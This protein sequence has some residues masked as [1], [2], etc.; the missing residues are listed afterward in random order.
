MRR[1]LAIAFGLSLALFTAPATSAH[2]SDGPEEVRA[3]SQTGVCS[4]TCD[5]QGCGLPCGV[6]FF[7]GTFTGAGWCSMPSA[8]GCEC[9]LF[10]CDPCG[11]GF[12][13]SGEE[14]DL[15]GTCGP[16][17]DAG[18]P[19]TSFGQCST[20][21]CQPRGGNG[22]AANCS[23][24][25]LVAT[26]FRPVSYVVSI[27]NVALTLSLSGS[28]TFA[29]GKPK[30]PPPPPCRPVAIRVFASSPLE[31]QNLGCVCVQG[32]ANPVVYG[33]GNVG[34]GVIGCADA[35]GILRA[36]LTLQTWVLPSGCNPGT[37]EDG[38]DGVPC[39][40]DDPMRQTAWAVQTQ[41]AC[42][43]DCNLDGMVTVDE[44]LEGVNIA[45]SNLDL[46]GC[47]SFDRNGDMMVSV[48]EILAAVSNTLDGCQGLLVEETGLR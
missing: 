12:I 42:S 18:L 44:L 32:T 6:R 10:E 30:P 40:E 26:T 41:F 46:Y 31:V 47:P 13:E 5:F 11:N 24:E 43:G 33:P 29:E 9:T 15:G 36:D 39:T 22:C 20:F 27:G 48:D 35:P 21:F 14:C 28:I 16:G 4:D 37:A 45:L 7:L 2:N 19:C 17:I 34:I 38:P 8:S 3:P 23:N 25:Q 1:W